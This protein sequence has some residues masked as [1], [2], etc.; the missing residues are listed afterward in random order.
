MWPTTETTIREVE[1]KAREFEF[2]KRVRVINEESQIVEICGADGLRRY[3]EAPNVEF[4]RAHGRKIVAIK[5]LS[6]GDDRGHLGERHGSSLFTTHKIVQTPGNSSPK[7]AHRWFD[8][9]ERSV[10]PG[11]RHPYS[12]DARDLR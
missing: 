12:R 10:R 4:V 9:S 3:L 7:V 2:A 11:V 1:N 6:K 8:E 5:L